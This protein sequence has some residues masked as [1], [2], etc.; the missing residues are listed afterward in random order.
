MLHRNR[1][2]VTE[3]VT[4]MTW[5]CKKCGWPNLMDMDHCHHCGTPRRNGRSGRAF[6]RIMY[7]H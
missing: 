7:R 2:F 5:T 6:R 1:L 4:T 3:E